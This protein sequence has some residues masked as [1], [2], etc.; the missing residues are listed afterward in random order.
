M[1]QEFVTYEQALALKELGFDEP[2]FGYYHEDKSLTY[3]NMVSQ[4]TNSFWKINNKVITAPLYQQAFRW[5]REKYGI[6]HEISKTRGGQYMP[7]VNGDALLDVTTEHKVGNN[8]IDNKG[9]QWMYDTYEESELACLKKLIE[10]VKQP[11][12]D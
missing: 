5:F 10:I 4:N 6:S 2:C 3:T 7:Y 1:K 12:K 8:L 9:Y 11:K